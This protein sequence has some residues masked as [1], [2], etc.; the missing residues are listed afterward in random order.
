MR[1]LT[2]MV[3]DACWGFGQQ[4]WNATN[5]VNAVQEGYGT[6]DCIQ[7]KVNDRGVSQKCVEADLIATLNLRVE[8][9]LI[10]H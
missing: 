5:D 4:G 8:E 3:V 9:A 2:T 7:Q 10:I 1:M 6:V